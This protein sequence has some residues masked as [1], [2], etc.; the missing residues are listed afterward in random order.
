[1]VKSTFV[2]CLIF[3][4]KKL[5]MIITVR[6]KMAIVMLTGSYHC[7]VLVEFCCFSRLYAAVLRMRC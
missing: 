4:F 2:V 6:M 5:A 1:M 3:L 7:Q